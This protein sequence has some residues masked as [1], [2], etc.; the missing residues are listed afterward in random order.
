MRKKILLLLLTLQLTGSDE[1]TVDSLF[2]QSEGLRSITT[3]NYITSGSARKFTTYPDLIGYDDGQLLVDSKKLS[4]SQTFLSSI[5]TNCDFIF[6]INGSHQILQYNTLNGFQNE[7]KSNLDSLWVGLDYKFEA[8]K[9]KFKPSIVVEIPI[10]ER[11]YYNSEFGSNYLRAL[12]VKG[13][14]RHFSDPM[15]S[16]L[17]I[18]AL[19]NFEKNIGSYK[20]Q[21]PNSYAI[22]YDL[23]F[24]VNPDVLLNFSF[25]QRFQTSVFENNTKINPSTN[26]P[27]MGIGATYSIDEENSI[28]ILGTTGNSS[29]APDSTFSISLWHKF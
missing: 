20:I 19:Q 18:S 17:Y 8:I 14:L 29:S 5:N 6:N 23:A 12:Y 24:V 13:Q 4:L 15:I 11:P 3:F 7:S 26:L 27:T 10:Y 21:Y 2:K 22:G 9:Q 1:I 16:T 25:E 28:S